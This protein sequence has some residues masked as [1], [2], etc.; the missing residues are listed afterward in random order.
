M[1]TG[2]QWA[3][4]IRGCL[5][6]RLRKEQFLRFA[7]DLD[8]KSPIK[9]LKLANLLLGSQK[10]RASTVDPLMLVYLESALDVGRLNSHDILFALYH[11]SKFRPSPTENDNGPSEKRAHGAE[12][13]NQELE[14]MVLEHLTRGFV[15]GRRPGTQLEVKQSLRVL[16]EWISLVASAESPNENLLQSLGQNS[17]SICDALG[18]L[19]L[20]MLENPKAAGVVDT[21]LPKGVQSFPPFLPQLIAYRPTR[22]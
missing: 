2:T 13:L 4:L 11:R 20:A 19:A 5:R 15:S 21:A 12:S 1:D 8:A 14:V 18:I 6:K 3:N 10:S 22:V 17:A 9:G 16:S 7:K